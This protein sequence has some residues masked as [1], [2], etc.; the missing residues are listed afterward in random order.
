MR[1]ITLLPDRVF[2]INK[3]FCSTTHRKIS[4][5]L[6]R[7][8]PPIKGKCGNRFQQCGHLKCVK[9]EIQKK[10]YFSTE[11]PK[12]KIKGLFHVF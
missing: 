11:C 3:L 4:I 7:K 12:P 10:W 2:T 9:T 8:N 5:P 1:Y 6:V